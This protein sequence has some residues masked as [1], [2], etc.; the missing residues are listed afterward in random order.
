MWLVDMDMDTDTNRVFIYSS[1]GICLSIEN[2]MAKVEPVLI[3]PEA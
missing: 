2:Q 3:G 1:D